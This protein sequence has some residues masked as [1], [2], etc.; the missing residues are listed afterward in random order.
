MI[1][2]MHISQWMRLTPADHRKL[3][4]YLAKTGQRLLIAFD[5]WSEKRMEWRNDFQKDKDEDRQNE[6]LGGRRV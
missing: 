5:R 6:G 1:Y 3:D 4:D 2:E